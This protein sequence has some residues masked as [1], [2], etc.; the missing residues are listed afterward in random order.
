MRGPVKSKR[1]N[2]PKPVQVQRIGQRQCPRLHLHQSLNLLGF[3]GRAHHEISAF[4]G[5]SFNQQRV[6]PSS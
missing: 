5:Q 6:S 4:L 1:G 3:K 2:M